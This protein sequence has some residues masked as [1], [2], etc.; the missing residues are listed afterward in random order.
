MLFALARPPCVAAQDLDFRRYSTVDGLPSAQTLTIHQDGQGYLWF[1]TSAGLARYDGTTFRTWSRADGLRGDTVT[2]ITE[3]SSGRLLIGL[4]EGG[5]D[6]LERGVVTPLVGP[7]FDG[8]SVRALVREP[9][10]VV[11]ALTANDLLQIVDRQARRVVP[12]ADLG[13][14]GPRALLRDRQGAVWIGAD[15]GLYRVAGSSFEKHGLGLPDGPVTSLVEDASGGLW[16][17]T[18]T[19]IFRRRG[20]R[21]VRVRPDGP[22]VGPIRA[23]TRAPDGTLWFC[24]ANGAVRVSS[25]RATVLTSENGLVDDRVN[26]VLVDHEGSIWF[27]TDGGAAKLVGSSFTTFTRGH[28]LPESFVVALT[29]DDSGVLWI[30]TRTGVSRRDGDGGFVTTIGAADFEASSITALRANGRDVLIGSDAGVHVWSAGRLRELVTGLPSAVRALQAASAGL[31]IGTDAGLWLLQRGSGPSR[32][33]GLGQVVVTDLALGSKGELWVG[34]AGSG[35]FARQSG[36]FEQLLPADVPTDTTIWSLAPG[37]DGSVWAATNGAGA[38][39]FLP[40]GTAVGLT[41]SSSGLAS[42]FVQQAVPT[43]EGRVWLYTNRG[44]DRWDPAVGIT[45]FDV[46]DGLASMAGNP[47]AGLRDEAG[48]LWFGTPEGLIRF[49]DSTVRGRG[50]PPVVVVE[51]VLA[52]GVPVGGAD[53]LALAPGQNDLTFVF[54]ALTYRNEASTRFQYRLLGGRSEAW[55]RPTSE[56]RV[57]LVRLPPGSY[58]FEVQAINDSGLWSTVPATVDFG[59]RPAV[60]QMPAVQI[61]V[62]LL[63]LLLVAIVFRRRVRQVEDERRRLRKMVDKRTLELV[64]KNT[65]LERMATTDELTGLPNRRFFLESMERELRKMTRLTAD[66]PLSLLVIDS[67]P[68]LTSWPR[69]YG[70]RSSRPSCASTEHRSA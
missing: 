52:G 48:D 14:R 43:R 13:L 58:R 50:V 55:S 26:A 16:A 11:W 59:I 57:A 53:L 25:G 19:G 18:D 39:R 30:A 5:V 12:P 45:H 49:D 7:G 4:R 68:E 10:G 46:D 40:D 28:G 37:A 24:S 17:G 56:R 31:W 32:E 60:W 67:R 35:L 44:L 38:L 65:Q 1:G 69:S 51:E 22:H 21:F 3:D 54:T 6:V 34:T 41:R 42:N 47:G 64:E 70:P 23:A 2:A 63:F 27:A 29:Q 66:Q 36:R 20:E 9:G 8:A 33:E 62:G 15:S 61:I